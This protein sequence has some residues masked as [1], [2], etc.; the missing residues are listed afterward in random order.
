[1]EEIA[2]VWAIIRELLESQRLAVLSTQGKEQP[3]SNLVAFAVTPDLQYLIF[4]TTRATRKYDNLSKHPLVSLLMD[5]RTNET[6]DFAEAAA[7][8]V[9]GRASEVQGD[10]RSQLI[11]T[12]LNRHPYLESFVTSPNCALFAVKVERYI[13]VTRFQD[14]REIIP[15]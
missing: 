6:T 7:V 10:E 1:M 12:Y 2:E 14:V 4:A 11:K 8:T 3:Y 5:N 9:L 15:G 13:M